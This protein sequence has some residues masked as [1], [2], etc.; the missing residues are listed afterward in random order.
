MSA[1]NRLIFDGD[2]PMAQGAVDLNRDL[3]LPLAELRAAPQTHN[4]P[5]R[6]DAETLA[7]LPEMRRG[8]IAAALV[9]V[10]GRIWREDDRNPV[11]YRTG[12]IAYA[13]AQAQLAYYRI[14]HLHGEA[15]L[16]LTAADLKEH[17]TTWE[18]TQDHS[19]LPV[20][21]VLGIEG[22]DSILWPEFVHHW[23]E[24]GVRVVSLS[25]YGLSTYCHGTG[26]GTEG[27]LFPPARDLLREME[28]IGMILD[29]THA[30]DASVRQALEL[31]SGR[32]VAS[33]QNCRALSPG[34]RQFPNDQLKAIIERDGV[35][36]HSMDS[37]MLY[38][39]GWED[40]AE[41]PTRRQVFARQEVTLED[42]ADHV[43]HVCQL[44]GNSLHAA[45]GGDTD[46]QGGREGTPDGI[47]TVADYQKLAPILQQRGYSEAD[48]DNVFYKNWQRF[49]ENYLPQS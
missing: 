38:H 1:D 21:F 39:K 17:M 31:F 35:I 6:L 43:D 36:G 5:D 26:T 15:R 22:A 24:A 25:H 10:V 20:G 7:T 12:D 46:G 3:T 47:D 8:R 29:L 30:A 13:Q 44:A 33:H 28:R 18:K 32:V 48:L 23:W 37:W 41:M 14:L 27:G 40:W 49:F 45:I 4:N 2:Y 11:G 16:L 42:F 34:E 19:E 9:K